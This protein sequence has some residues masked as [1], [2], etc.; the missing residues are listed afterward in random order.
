[1]DDAQRRRA[2]NEAVFR[3]VN[4]R[5]EDLQREFALTADEPLH[6]VCECDRLDCNVPLDVPIDVYER[7]RADPARFI[8]KPGH[9]DDSVEDV[10][11]SVSDYLIVR[12]RA[13]APRRVAAESDPR[14]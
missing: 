5:I 8:V 2:A 14:S 12:K 13:G 11:D 6:L 4:E 9:Q 10:V 3:E 7:T 1:M